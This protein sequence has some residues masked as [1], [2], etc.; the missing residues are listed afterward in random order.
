VPIFIEALAVPRV[1]FHVYPRRLSVRYVN[2]FLA[3]VLLA[4]APCMIGCGEKA[5]EPQAGDPVASGPASEFE[6][7]TDSVD[8]NNP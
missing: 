2:L 1:Q 7:T 8:P 6:S 5:A 3:A 4:F